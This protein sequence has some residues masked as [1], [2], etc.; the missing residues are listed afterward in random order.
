M[1][2]S[3]MP[4]TAARSLLSPLKAA[5]PPASSASSPAPLLSAPT[6][7][8]TSTLATA[9]STVAAVT[10][11]TSPSTA[12][13]TMTRFAAPLS[14]ARCAPH[15]IPSRSFASPPPAITPTRADPPACPGGDNGLPPVVGLSGQTYTFAPGTNGV[16]PAQIKAMDQGCLVTGTCTPATNGIN[17][18]V[19]SQ[20]FSKYPTANSQNCAN[21]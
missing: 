17:A 12:S 15:S 1:P 21:A 19:I 7:T 13:I 20:V 8:T 11:P 14:P 16:G 10:R 4:L 18:N 2:A 6:L 5:T 9:P 3:A